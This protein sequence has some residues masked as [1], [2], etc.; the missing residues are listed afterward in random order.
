MATLLR[1]PT[2]LDA[3]VRAAADNEGVTLTEWWL[4][5]GR[6]RLHQADMN[7]EEAAKFINA[8]PVTRRVLDRLAQ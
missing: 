5:A 1:V 3:R 6:Q 4:E 8:D 2:D 7:I